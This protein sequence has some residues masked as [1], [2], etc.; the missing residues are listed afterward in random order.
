[1]RVPAAPGPPG[2]RAPWSSFSSPDVSFSSAGG[3]RASPPEAT[4]ASTASWIA[5]ER[6]VL[7]RRAEARQTGVSSS[8][9]PVVAGA[10]E[11][12]GW[13][14]AGGASFAT[15]RGGARGRVV[16]APL[17]SSS[18]T[19]RGGTRAGW[20]G[21]RRASAFARGELGELGLWGGEGGKGRARGCAG[22]GTTRRGNREGTENENYGGFGNPRRARATPR[23]VA[24]EMSS[25]T[26]PRDGGAENPTST[27]GG[28]ASARSAVRLA[29][30]R[31]PLSAS[32]STP[33][34]RS[35]PS[36]R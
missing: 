22:R 10:E 12:A 24:P 20:R 3:T 18:S 30:R 2:T 11:E 36:S 26:V 34:P 17:G 33:S 28:D 8:N 27:R 6:R 29:T 23:G 9:A 1:M 21:A 5:R 31:L 32:A 16:R 25:V 19:A 7:A 14:G 15:G 35:W 13:G 4:A